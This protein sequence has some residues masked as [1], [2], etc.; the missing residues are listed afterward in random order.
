M[1]KILVNGLAE[2]AGKTASVLG[3][4]SHL[5]KFGEVSLLKP[6]AGNNYWHD[7]PI[8]VEG[9]R[10]G[11]IYG[12][13][14]KLLS[15]ASGVKEEIVNPLHK[16]WTPSKLAGTGGTAENTVMLDRIYDGEK[17]HALL[18]SQI[19][20]STGIFPFLENVDNLEKYSDEKE[21]NRLV[22]SI[23]PEAFQNSRS[24]VKGSDFLIIE[25]YSKIAIPYP[26]SD[27]DLVFTVEP[28]R[29]YLSDGEKFEEA[30]SLALEIYAEYGFEET[31]AGKCLEAINSE[32]FTIFPIDLETAPPEG[33][34]VEYEDLAGAVIRQLEND[35]AD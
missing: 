7:Y 33:G 15:K 20:I 14:A 11:R 35:P 29:A 1:K 23:Y 21:H 34:Y 4:Y 32:A 30:E 2:S 26:V 28:G 24:E 31:R 22:E 10:E 3:L 18:N 25:S 8:L 16:L 27:V 9:I 19:K 6:L 17:I 12:K 13:D 5:R